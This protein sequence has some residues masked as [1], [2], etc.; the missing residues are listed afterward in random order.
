MAF[1]DEA[2]DTGRDASGAVG[3]SDVPFAL[4]RDYRAM[5][6]EDEIL[7]GG[8]L[9]RSQPWPERTDGLITAGG[10]GDCD[11]DDDMYGRVTDEGY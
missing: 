8:W 4:G 5:T 7:N 9:P 1:R 10:R 11:L 2:C 3:R 6:V